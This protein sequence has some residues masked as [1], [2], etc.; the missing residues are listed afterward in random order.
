MIQN[1]TKFSVKIT[2]YRSY[3]NYGSNG[4]HAITIIEIMKQNNKPSHVVHMFVNWN[5]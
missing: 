2:F 1:E 4:K 5:I 3:E